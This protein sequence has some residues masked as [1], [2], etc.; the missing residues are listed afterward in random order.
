[1]PG[2]Q[3]VAFEGYDTLHKCNTPPPFPS[4]NPSSSQ[5]QGGQAVSDKDLDF[6]DIEI[7]GSGKEVSRLPLQ[8]VEKANKQASFQD[9]TSALNSSV[10]RPTPIRSGFPQWIWWVAGALCLLWLMSKH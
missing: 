10:T 7:K 6:Y 1:M 5:E 2:G 9:K 4:R 8:T 3:W